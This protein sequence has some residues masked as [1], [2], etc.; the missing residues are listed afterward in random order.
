MENFFISAPGDYLF[1]EEYK[2]EKT[3]EVGDLEPVKEEEFMF[4]TFA[5]NDNNVKELCPEA[6]VLGDDG[7]FHI[8]ENLNPSAVPVD[9]EFKRLVDSVLR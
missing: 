2:T 4:T 7:V 5:A 6:I 8:T 1:S 9:E 3:E